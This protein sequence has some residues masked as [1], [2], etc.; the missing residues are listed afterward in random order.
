MK[1]VFILVGSLIIA[2][3]ATVLAACAEV[4]DVS[5]SASANVYSIGEQTIEISVSETDDTGCTFEESISTSDL[6]V[7]DG[8]EG[9]EVT[10]VEYINET[11]I[12]VTLSGK[13]TGEVGDNGLLGY[14]SVNGGMTHGGTGSAYLNVLNPVMTTT[15]ISDSTVADIRTFSST[16]KL[17]YGS[18]VAENLKG[19]VLPDDNGTLEV[20]L[21]A[22]GELKVTVTGFTPTAEFTH[23][24][25]M[26]PAN[27]T[28]FEKELY[29]YVGL[30]AS[31][32]LA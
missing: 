24:V 1:K 17:P 23:P 29:V 19:I 31:Y 5:L 14:V 28:T 2:L 18:F 6:S 21:T 12:A 4:E 11:T 3:L 13:V 16:F 25:V 22:A 30:V 32:S 9:K 10:A 27:A 15:G 26:I 20:S 8:L 7:G